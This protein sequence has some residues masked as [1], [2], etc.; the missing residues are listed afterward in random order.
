MMEE[1]K[2]KAL[3]DLGYV[4]GTIKSQKHC[5]QQMEGLVG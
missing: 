2:K 1:L 4:S 5:T 3:K